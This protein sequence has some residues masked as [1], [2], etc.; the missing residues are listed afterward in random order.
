MVMA[1]GVEFP[2]S[3]QMQGAHI[4]YGFLYSRGYWRWSLGLGFDIL[5]SHCLEK[6][7]SLTFSQVNIPTYGT[8]L[9]ALWLMQSFH[10][11]VHFGLGAEA[12]YRLVGFQKTYPNDELQDRAKSFAHIVAPLTWRVHRRLGLYQSLGFSAK[13]IDP[14]WQ[15]GLRWFL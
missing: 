12:R 1:N 2:V 14:S 3:L 15:F 4:G 9:T 6:E 11:D 8:S 5:Q 7:K 13:E 10:E